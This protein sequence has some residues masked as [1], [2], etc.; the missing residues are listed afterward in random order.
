MHTKANHYYHFYKLI[1][2]V[3][4]CIWPAPVYAFN[5]YICAQKP[6]ITINGCTQKPT[7]TIH[8]CI[9]HCVDILAILSC[10]RTENDNREHLLFCCLPLL[11]SSPT[12]LLF[13]Y[14][15]YLHIWLLIHP[16]LSC[17]FSPVL[18]CRFPNIPRKQVGWLFP[19]PSFSVKFLDYQKLNR[20]FNIQS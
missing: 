19:G 14:L 16:Y 8:E 3:H 5:H 7:I 6:T 20:I 4:N 10:H 12:K 17:K 15:M 13:H 2:L 18:V 1:Q 9:Y 11:G